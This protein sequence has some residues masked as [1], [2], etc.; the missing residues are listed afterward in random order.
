MRRSSRRPATLSVIR[1]RSLI[2]L[3]S[4]LLI[5]LEGLI[6]LVTHFVERS[7]ELLGLDSEYDVERQG[8]WRVLRLRFDAWRIVI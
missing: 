4:L 6:G 2:I 8:P 1:S 5:I 3:F 7:G